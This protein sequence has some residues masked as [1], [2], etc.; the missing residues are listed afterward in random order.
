MSFITID[1]F[2]HYLILD[3]IL[4]FLFLC[5]IIF[6]DKYFR[7]NKGTIEER[8]RKYQKDFLALLAVGLIV[9]FM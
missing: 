8:R 2:C 6:I 4:S 3:I 7:K 5:F 1:S 9:Y